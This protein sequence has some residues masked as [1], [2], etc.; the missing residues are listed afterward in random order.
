MVI[1]LIVLITIIRFFIK[2][3]KIYFASNNSQESTASNNEKSVTKKYS[4]VTI[5]GRKRDIMIVGRCFFPSSWTEEQL[6][7]VI[8]DFMH[9]HKDTITLYQDFFCVEQM[10][11]DCVRMR[12]IFE[13]DGSYVKAYPIAHQIQKEK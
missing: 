5:A 7:K 10:L 8:V 12:I 13:K 11:A 2:K 3:I 1:Q 4:T 6:G 9:R